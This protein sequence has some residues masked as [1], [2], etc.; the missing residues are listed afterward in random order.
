M[1]QVAK[2]NLQNQYKKKENKFNCIEYDFIITAF[3]LKSN[4][5]TVT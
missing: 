4:H 1:P 2:F 5:I 3:S